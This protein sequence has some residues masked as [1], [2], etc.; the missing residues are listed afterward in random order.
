MNFR[1]CTG[2]AAIVCMS[3]ASCYPYNEN[4]QKKKSHKGTEKTAPATPDEVKTKAEE[5]AK[6]KAAEELKQ[7]EAA[8]NTGSTENPG[9]VTPPTDGPKPIEPKR[10]DYPVAS[11]VPGKDGYVFS[12]YNNKI[13]SVLDEQ[14]RP[15]A[16]GTLV[17]DP[18][19]KLSEKKFFRVP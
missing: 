19:Y 9:N 11:K 13:I 6:K 18:T 16:S 10:N 15:I 12:P 7:K 14:D 1:L 5:E 17:Q 3:L 4:S 8:A 2:L